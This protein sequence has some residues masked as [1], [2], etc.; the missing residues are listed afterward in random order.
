MLL[1]VARRRTGVSG[2][3]DVSASK[4]RL[5]PLRSVAVSTAWCFSHLVR[6]MR[7]ACM[8][9]QGTFFDRVFVGICLEKPSLPSADLGH[10][11]SISISCFGTDKLS[12]VT[13]PV[14][15]NLPFCALLGMC[16]TLQ[17]LHAGVHTALPYAVVARVA[18]RPRHQQK[19]FTLDGQT[20]QL[21]WTRN[22]VK[23]PP[24]PSLSSS[25]LE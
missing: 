11:W 4:P 6:V 5:P 18:C 12:P 1:P 8:M 23:T 21:F 13:N 25:S 16:A 14:G 22:V 20:Y 17:K 9:R 3:G 24:Y 19:P 15:Q 10:H 7:P 2:Y